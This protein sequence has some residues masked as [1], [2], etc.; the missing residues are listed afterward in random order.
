MCHLATPSKLRTS[1]ADQLVGA[2]HRYR[3][4][5]GFNPAKVPCFFSG[6]IAQSNAHPKLHHKLNKLTKAPKSEE[7]E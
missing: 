1:F 7:P 3:V 2:P 5:T 6:P 4:L